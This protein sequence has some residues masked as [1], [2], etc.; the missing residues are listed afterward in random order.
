MSKYQELKSKDPILTECFFA[1]DNKQ[2]EEGI[3]EKGLEGKKVFSAKHLFIGLY[4]TDEGLKQFVESCE[5][6][7]EDITNGCDPQEVYDYEFI[8]HE[9]GYVG[10][11]EGAIDIVVTYF[12]AERAREVKRQFGHKEIK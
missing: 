10:N 8:N 9:C 3:K 12:G 5:K 6:I 7:T 1:F 11:D 4:G 2:F